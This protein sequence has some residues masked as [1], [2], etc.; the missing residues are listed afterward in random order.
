MK[1]FDIIIIGGGPS[2]MTAALYA[3]RAGRSVLVIEQSTFGGQISSSPR[4]ENYPSIKAI[5][6]VEFSDNLYEQ[7]T[8]LGAEFDLA[9]VK[10]IKKIDNSFYITTVYDDEYKSNVAIIA[11]GVVHRKTGVKDEEKFIGKGISYCATCDGVFYKG[12]E[13][14]LIGD[15]NTALQY[16]L[17]LSTYCKKVTICTLFDKF[18]GDNE[19]VERIKSKNNIAYFHN[20]EL[21]EFIHNESEV[22]GAIFFDKVS[23][24]M[25]SFSSAAIFVAI[26]QIPSNDLFKNYVDLDH[27][28]IETNENMETKTPGLYAIGD[29]RVKKVRQLITACSDGAIAAINAEKYLS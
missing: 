22:T 11:N 3:L 19:L 1:T 25:K 2:G 10:E 15:A 14:L 4:V 28:Y 26:G 6:G 27:G 21:Q 5:S 29:T 7:I 17:L 20:L 24:N 23:K 8:A 18:F 12:E 13:V 16:A 9:K